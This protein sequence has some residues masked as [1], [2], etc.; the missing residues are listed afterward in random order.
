MIRTGAQYLES[1]RDGRRVQC[2]GELI[3]DVTTHPKTKGFAASI[4]Q[5]YDLHHDPAHQ[6][7]LTFVDSDGERRALHWMLPTDKEQVVWRR[8]YYEFWWKTFKGAIFTRPPCSMNCVMFAQVDDP[9]PWEENSTLHDGHPLAQNIR[10]QFARLKRDDLSISPMFLDV[11][12]DRS[13]D[14]A[15]G[16]TPMLKMIDKNDDGIIVR[17][18]KAIGTGM[19]FANELLIGNLWRPGQTPEQTIYALVPVASPG[20]TIFCR[21]SN[22]EPDADPFDRPLASIGDEL[23][24]MA[25]FDDVF[26]P[27]ERIQHLGNPTH[28]Q[29]YPQRQ[30]DWVH[31]ETQIRH[32]ANAEVMVGLALLVTQALGTAGSPVIQSSVADLIRFR[33]TCR[34]FAIAAEE[35][36]FKTPG[37]MYK[38]NNIFVD[39]G[40]AYYLENVSAMIEKLI[41]FCGRGVIV[42]PTMADFDDRY[43]GPKLHE[44]F[45]G[46]GISAIDRTKIFKL[47]HERFLTE[48]GTR[49]EMFEKFNGTPLYLIKLL[50]MQRTEYQIDGPLTELARDILG[51]GSVA[52]IAERAAEADRASNYA[53]AAYQPDYARAQD[54]RTQNQGVGERVDA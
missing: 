25:Y 3:D 30:F 23:D 28:S 54:Q 15:M 5:Y 36:G 33:E 11:Q 10:D 41:D 47:I 37:G 51:I 19:A 26:I 52:E 2:G 27:W 18:W 35:T 53:A 43:L 21:P 44:V 1:I 4:A 39:F 9:E 38:P 17:G 45:K 31:V 13:R 42:Y 29:L 6:D 50:T 12:Y 8:K 20:L 22:A 40:R 48:W 32:A 46:P 7:L 49:K 34:A 24:G 16:E 14:D